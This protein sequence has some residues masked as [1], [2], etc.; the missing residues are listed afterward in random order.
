MFQSLDLGY[1]GT[2]HRAAAYSEQSRNNTKIPRDF[3][4]NSSVKSFGCAP[5]V[6]LH[7]SNLSDAL[8][9]TDLQ[10]QLG[11]GAV[12]KGTSAD[13]SGIRTGDLSVTGPTLLTARLHAAA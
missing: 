6:H 11:L 5:L 8:I 12:L 10:E 7:F 3:S 1:S 2:S 4:I 9:Q 13:F